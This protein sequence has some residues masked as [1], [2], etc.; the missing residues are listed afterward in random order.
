MAAHLLPR[1][2]FGLHP[3]VTLTAATA[4]VAVIS[5]AFT[6]TL[7]VLV[8]SFGG[9]LVGLVVGFVLLSVLVGGLVG[10]QFPAAT[11]AVAAEPNRGP[12]ASAMYAADLA[13]GSLGAVLA[14]AVLVPVLGVS[15]CG[16][17]CGVAAC[18]LACVCV[19]RLRTH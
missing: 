10:V 3:L 18:A 16:L 12:A 1:G 14:G 9:G 19:A 5:F 7:G 11:E 2:R 15:G 13:G 8:G 17:L 6:G 4:L